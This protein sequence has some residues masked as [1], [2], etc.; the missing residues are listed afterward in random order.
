MATGPDEA[1]APD[2]LVGVG[3]AED[4][5]LDGVGL[6]LT[7]ES[8][9]FVASGLEDVDS[10][11]LGAAGVAA[12]GAAHDE[13]AIAAATT[14]AAFRPK[15]ICFKRSPILQTHHKIILVPANLSHSPN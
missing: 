4:G 7:V 2:E 12:G 15:V 5:V 10:A 11:W 13:A 1:V 14:S 6:G 9:E 3:R 8:E